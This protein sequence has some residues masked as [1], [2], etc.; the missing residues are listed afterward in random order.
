VAQGAE[1]SPRR[2]DYLY[3]YMYRI[4][5]S[6]NAGYTQ[7]NGAVSNVTEQ[8]ISHHT[9]P[10]HTLSAAATVRVSHAY[11]GAAGPVFKMASHQE[12]AYYVLCVEVSRSVITEQREFC[13]RFKKDIILVWCV[14]FKR[15]DVLSMRNT[16][17]GP[18]TCQIGESW[19]TLRYGLCHEDIWGG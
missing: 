12:K 16:L 15:T 13:A 14:Y 1:C 9:R 6:C 19:Y 10:Q 11:C 4:S 7:N 2:L 8:C 17:L 3:Q 5:G 18:R